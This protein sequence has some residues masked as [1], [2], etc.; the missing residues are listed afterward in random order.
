MGRWDRTDISRRIGRFKGSGGTNMRSCLA[1]L[2]L[3]VAA[4][5]YGCANP[6]ANKPKA[7]VGNAQPEANTARSGAMEELMISSGNSKVE[8]VASIVTRSH[9]GSFKKFSG[10]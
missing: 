7:T 2:I 10:T 5:S 8:F 1:T 4:I 9:Q 6:A 3:I